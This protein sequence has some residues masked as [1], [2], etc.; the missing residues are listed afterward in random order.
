MTNLLQPAGL[1]S[2]TVSRTGSDGN[3]YES[4]M[5]VQV[6]PDAVFPLDGT[7]YFLTNFGSQLKANG[8]AI[9]SKSIQ[10]YFDAGWQT[11]G[12]RNSATVGTATTTTCDAV[13][14]GLVP[15]PA[16]KVNASDTLYDADIHASCTPGSVVLGRS[17]ATWSVEF[18]AGFVFFCINTQDSGLGTNPQV[19]NEQNCVEVDEAGRLGP[20]ARLFLTANSPSFSLVAR[21][22]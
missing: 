7:P 13:V 15:P 9:S 8:T 18:E 19:T 2:W 4:T 5:F 10:N 6:A 12:L 11:R 1:T 21:N 17:V 22:Y 14:S 20:R 3:V 16:A